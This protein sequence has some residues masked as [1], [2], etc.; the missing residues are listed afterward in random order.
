MALTG[1]RDIACRVPTAIFV[2][3]TNGPLIQ[4]MRSAVDALAKRCFSNTSTV[5]WSD[6]LQRKCTLATRRICMVTSPDEAQYQVGVYVLYRNITKLRV[7]SAQVDTIYYCAIVDAS[8][9][10]WSISDIINAYDAS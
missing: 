3:H 6:P 8:R 5:V 2:R 1:G 7:D 4:E 9:S 10:T